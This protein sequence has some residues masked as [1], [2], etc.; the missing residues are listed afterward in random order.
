MRADADADSVRHEFDPEAV[1][2]NRITGGGKY[3]S[4]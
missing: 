4:S 1:F 2:G 3:N